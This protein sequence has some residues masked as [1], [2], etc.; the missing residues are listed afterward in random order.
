MDHREIN[1]KWYTSF[2]EKSMMFTIETGEGEDIEIPA[3]YEVCGTCDGKGSHVNPSID[4]HGLSREDFDD[5]PDFAEDYF[6]GVYDIACN[7]CHGRRVSPDVNWEKLNP[8]LKK[9]VENWIEDFYGYQREC[10]YERRM[11]C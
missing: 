5:D 10:E 8:E 2:D 9:Y 7:E 6:S 1:R 11:G 4:S 3:I